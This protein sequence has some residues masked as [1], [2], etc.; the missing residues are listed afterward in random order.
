MVDAS[1]ASPQQG[2]VA[3]MERNASRR[4]HLLNEHTGDNINVVYYTH[5]IFIN[6]SLSKLNHLMR[7]RRMNLARQM[8]TTLYDLLFLIQSEL[9]TSEPVHILSGYRTPETNAKL[10]R[11]LPKVAKKSLHI[12]G[13]AADIYVPGLPVQQ[14]HEAALSFKAGG[15][16]LYSKSNFVHID[17]GVVRHWGS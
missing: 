1:A 15:V 2:E 4:L 7:D 9:G 11:R 6:D 17:T 5:G 14:V 16:G 8:D 3:R 13:R 12:E 10:R